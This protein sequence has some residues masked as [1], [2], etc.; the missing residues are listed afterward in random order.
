MVFEDKVLQFS[1]FFLK[2]HFLSTGEKY[3][4]FSLQISFVAPRLEAKTKQLFFKASIKGIP[5]DS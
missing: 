3:I 2:N 4:A 5:N 1:I